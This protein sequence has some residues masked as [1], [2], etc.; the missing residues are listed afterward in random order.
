MTKEGFT[1]GVLCYNQER[2]IVE[3]LESIKYQIEN[4]GEDYNVN[5]IISDDCSTDRTV[6]IASKWI[7][8]NKNLFNS[9][10]ILCP[11]KNQGIVKNITRL[12]CAV[13]DVR[14]KILAG[15]DLYYKNNIFLINNDCDI[16]LTHTIKFK[17]SSID[18]SEELYIF[19]YLLI[20]NNLGMLVNDY[21][22]YFCCVE[23][24][25]V[26]FSKKFLNQELFDELK[27]YTWIEDVPMWKCIFSKRDTRI[28]VL[29]S[30]YVLYRSN[31]G[32]SSNVHHP[33]R[34]GFDEDL[35][36]IQKKIFVKDRF[37]NKV[38]HKW[39]KSIKKRLINFYYDKHNDKLVDFNLE[40]KKVEIE[41]QA[42]LNLIQ[43]NASEFM[44]D[45]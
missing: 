7:E 34:K 29:S 43:L 23:S 41:G 42:Y 40:L 5:L 19:K 4:Y 26:F 2:F 8:R 21:L 13:K 24:P 1:F 31:E 28:R 15:D 36:K 6:D 25:G 27:P 14:F 38:F 10:E 22:Q 3:H 11:K 20:A 44:Q 12:L 16:S 17:G 33:K 45:V 37:P 9:V 39:E 35:K 30:A 32:I 18:I